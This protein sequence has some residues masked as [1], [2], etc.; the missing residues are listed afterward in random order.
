MNAEWI[1]AFL[2]TAVT[3]FHKVTGVALTHGEPK[4]TPSNELVEPVSVLLGVTGALRGHVIFGFD[5]DTALKV[6]TAMVGG[7]LS[8]LDEMC[9]SALGVLGNMMTGNA[10]IKLDDMSWHADMCPPAVII[11]KKVDLYGAVPRF[12]AT[13]LLS[14]LGGLRLS[15]GLRA[16]LK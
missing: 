9:L 6:A 2:D 13:P 7:G 10:L 12:I 8:E 3:V 15:I 16:S 14:D 5:Q 11:G 4:V 1:N